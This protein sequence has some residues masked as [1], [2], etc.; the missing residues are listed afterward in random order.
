MHLGGA[1]LTYCTNC[2]PGESVRDLMEHVN[3]YAS[4]V[5]AHVAP[6]EPFGIGLRVSHEASLALE[7]RGSLDAL[8]DALATHGLYVFTINGFP[9]GRFHG[10]RVKE[11]VYRPDWLERDRLLYTD[12]LARLLSD[13][14]PEGAIGSI[15]TVPGASKDRANDSDSI[16]RMGS[17]L[18]E[19]AATLVDLERKSGRTICLAIEPEPCCFLETVEETVAFFEDAL[20][21]RHACANLVRRTNIAPNEA[22]AALR[23]H[24][25]VCFDA[26]HAAVEF[27]DPDEAVERLARAGL[28]IGKLQLSAGLR[29]DRPDAARAEL[30]RFAD[31]VYLHQVVARRGDSL[32]RYLDLPDALRDP[33]AANDEEWRVHFHV[34]IFA[35]ELGAFASTNDFLEALLARHRKAPLSPH[36]EVETYTWD[37]LPPELRLGSVV[38]SIARELSWVKERLAP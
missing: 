10:A 36:L 7:D 30:E 5:R 15:S 8:R 16:A 28:R 31:D 18:V 14:V 1:Q 35:R 17:L 27:E 22:E 19:H 33:A 13:L 38:E 20:L 11:R 21:S 37:V 4:A 6:H 3:R 34:P 25:T 24:L 2:H 9:Y 29:I 32:V 12:R 26:C 23:R